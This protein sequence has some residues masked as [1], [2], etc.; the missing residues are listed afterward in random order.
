MHVQS[1]MQADVL[2]T[3]T[4]IIPDEVPLLYFWELNS[5]VNIKINHTF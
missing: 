1:S 4:I 2:N 5:R 3:M